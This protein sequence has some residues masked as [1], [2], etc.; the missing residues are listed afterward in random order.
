MAQ[1]MAGRRLAA[2]VLLCTECHHI[3]QPELVAIVASTGCER[4]GGWT[5]IAQTDP[6]DLP[7]PRG[8]LVDAGDDRSTPTVP[9]G[10][11]Q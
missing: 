1:P 10:G 5:W 7:R 2:V 4:C 9:P 8:P 11:T 6:P 3:F